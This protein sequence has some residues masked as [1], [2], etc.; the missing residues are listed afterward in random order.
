MNLHR[1]HS[2]FTPAGL[3]L[4]LAL[5]ALLGPTPS[6]RADLLRPG[7]TQSFPDIAGNVNGVLDYHY[8]SATGVGTLQVNNA[9]SILA[10][11]PNLSN[12]VYVTD[13]PGQPRSESLQLKLDG[14]GN[15]RTGVEGNS[16]SMYGS[17]TINGHSYSGL[18][19]QGTPTAFGFQNPS[20]MPAGTAAFDVNINLT[21]GLLKEAYGP[22]AY[23]RISPEIG[24]TFNGLFFSDFSGK[25]VW[26][27]VRAYHAPPAPIPEPSTFAIL[28]AC[29]GVAILYR[30]RRGRIRTADLNAADD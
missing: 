11:G 28:L 21:G 2:V 26:T 19:L 18:L 9:P 30:N 29:G 3:T 23:I 25:K 4:T 10:I 15:L 24:S 7:A 6:A 12:E 22:D 17:V 1:M 13:L 16:F 27:N 14:L 20:G 5:A 8:D